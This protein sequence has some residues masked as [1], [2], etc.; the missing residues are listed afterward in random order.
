MPADPNISAPAPRKPSSDFYPSYMKKEVNAEK[1][2]YKWKNHWVEVTQRENDRHY[3]KM[4]GTVL[5]FIV[6]PMF[7]VLILFESRHVLAGL[8]HL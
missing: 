6:A 3:R 7:A 1:H 8:L 4:F 5:K 2:R